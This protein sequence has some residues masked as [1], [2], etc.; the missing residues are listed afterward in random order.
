MTTPNLLQRIQRIQILSNH[1]ADDLLAG[2]YH[3]A[4]KGKGMEFEEVRSYTPG[5]EVRHIDWNVTARM[6][7]PYIKLF[8]EE[9][10]ITVFLLIDISHSTQFGPITENKRDFLIEIAAAI[11]FSAAKN[12]DKVGAILF[13]DKVEMAIPPKQG[14]RHVMHIIDHAM[15]QKPQGKHSD[16]GPALAAFGKINKKNSICFILSDFLF[17]PTE[18]L[19]LLT[20]KR[21]DLIAIMAVSP[22][23]VHFPTPNALTQLQDIESQESSLID[24]NS[25]KEQPSAIEEYRKAH[26]VIFNKSGSPLIVLDTSE[27][28]IPALKTFFRLRSRQR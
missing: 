10:E 16:L 12:S 26:K 19:T 6:Q 23:E 5:D 21:H 14:I 28:Y 25:A 8:R 9:R 27:P 17:P 2:A 4:F 13:S 22:A 11:A 1:L 20:A 3:S 15:T 7:H 18:N 24:W